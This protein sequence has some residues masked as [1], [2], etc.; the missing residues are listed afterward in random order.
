MNDDIY[1]NIQILTSL[2]VL[3]N[4]QK[5]KKLT[6]YKNKILL[7]DNTLINNIWRTIKGD[8]RENTY[9][10]INNLYEQT[11]KLLYDSKTSNF[12]IIKTLEQSYSGV[13]NIM[14]TYNKD[15]EYYYKLESLLDITKNKLQNYKK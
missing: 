6:I 8:N 11:L 2:K 14:E 5:N 12:D 13:N 4:I 7:Y 10:F 15:D 9:K 1:D 3:S